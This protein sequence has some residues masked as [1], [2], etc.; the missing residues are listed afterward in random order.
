M[1]ETLEL[2]VT[3][4]FPEY[5]IQT[6]EVEG[7]FSTVIPIKYPRYMLKQQ[8]IIGQSILKEDGIL[9]NT[10]LGFQLENLKCSTMY[11]GV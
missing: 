3:R 10:Y 1:K 4:G 7:T 9:V 8:I 5:N 11:Y 2:R 6:E